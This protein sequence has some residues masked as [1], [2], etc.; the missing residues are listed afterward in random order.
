M[1][2]FV[3]IFCISSVFWINSQELSDDDRSRLSNLY[4]EAW[5]YIASNSDSAISLSLRLYEESVRLNSTLHQ[6]YALSCLAET[7]AYLEDFQ[8][9]IDYY[10]RS[11]DLYKRINDPQGLSAS[12]GN[13][14]NM[15]IKLSEYEVAKRFYLSALEIERKY[16]DTLGMIYSL[17]NLGVV[18]KKLLNFDTAI[19]HYEYCKK[20]LEE[21][22]EEEDY[23]YA[24]LL[25][26]IA[27]LYITRRKNKEKTLHYLRIAERT[28]SEKEYH[29]I[30]MAVYNNL[31]NYFE[32]FEGDYER[33][34]HYFLLALDKADLQK[35][36]EDKINAHKNLYA[37]YKKKEDYK[38]SLW[39]FE[40]LLALRT[41]REKE[42]NTKA[43]ARL[44]IE[45]EFQLKATAD[46]LRLLKEKEIMQSKMEVIQ[47]RQIFLYGGGVI[48][49]FFLLILLNRYRIIR[50]K[51]SIIS[52][53]KQEVELRNKEVMDSIT[54]A[55]KIQKAYMPIETTLQ[56]IYSDS[57]ILNIP[58]EYVSGDFHW[59]YTKRHGSHEKEI[60][61]FLAAADC[62][63]HGVPGALMSVI[64]SNALNEVV[65][66]R[67]ITAP[68]EILNQTRE[69]VKANLKSTQ[70]TDT[71]DGMDISLLVTHYFEEDQ[72]TGKENV[73]RAS[74]AGAN[75]PLW[76]IP[77]RNMDRFKDSKNT[78][79]LF[80]LRPNKQPIGIYTNEHPFQE[81]KFNLYENDIVYLFS[82]GY[83]DQFGGRSSIERERG[84]KKYKAAAFKRLLIQLK[85]QPMQ[86]QLELINS[87]FQNWKGE[88]EQVD[89]V[90]VIGVRM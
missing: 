88:L 17:S 81:H 7:Y 62:T 31:G 82:D 43:L 8:L 14:A 70:N 41:T 54:Y 44:E 89:D 32:V 63:G 72:Q 69:I 19:G 59:F 38:N 40:E 49:L 1:K 39:H 66:N 74:W 22:A 85:N 47:Q 3:I 6:A 10:K 35:S 76:V 55:Q 26:N 36:I 45:H 52:I 84:G 30:L 34:S 48:S 42:E 21:K 24:N 78:D 86:V 67:G 15:Y 28:A 25:G 13:I 33:A 12:Y 83:Q 56:K 18:E 65:V 51:N 50:K 27:S 23:L 60:T 79:G 5:D 29:Q 73:Y 57:F 37:V 4:D 9:A 53:Q 77:N 46:S 20:L 90:C 2:V 61:R 16:G 80:E 75:N 71:K 87:E 64:C 58:K 11:I 68:G